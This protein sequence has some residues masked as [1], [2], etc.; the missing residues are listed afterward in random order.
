MEV[1]VD[2]EKCQG[3]AR[4]HVICPDV[5]QLDDEGFAT[6]TAGAVPVALEAA[7]EEAALNCPEGAITAT[8]ARTR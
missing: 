1:H 4:C 5:F 6:A 2:S 7:A 8:G 3:H